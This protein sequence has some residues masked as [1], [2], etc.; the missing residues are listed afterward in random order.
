MNKK[1]MEKSL[2][3]GSVKQGVELLP[4]GG[5]RKRHVTPNALSETGIQLWNLLTN[6]EIFS[7]LCV[8][9]RILDKF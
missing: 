4:G 7:K 8:S 6:P 3:V 5:R 1:E 2:T 9:Q